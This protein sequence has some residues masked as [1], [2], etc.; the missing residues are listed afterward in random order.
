MYDIDNY[1]DSVSNIFENEIIENKEFNMPLGKR[2][3]IQARYKLKKTRN[4]FNPGNLFLT[5]VKGFDELPGVTKQARISLGFNQRINPWLSLGTSVLYGG[6]NDLAIGALISTNIK[7]YI[8]GIHSDDFTGAIFPRLGTGA[9]FG[10][11]LQR[12]FR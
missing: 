9:G 10:F 12:S 5:M 7:R 3:F 11:I 6:F 4:E 1:V 2:L 8:I